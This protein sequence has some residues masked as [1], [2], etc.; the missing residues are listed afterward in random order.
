MDKPYGIHTPMYGVRRATFGIKVEEER[1]DSLTACI[2]DC[3]QDLIFLY[4]L[5]LLLYALM[6]ICARELITISTQVHSS[7]AYA[8][9]PQDQYNCSFTTQIML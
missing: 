6:W 7:F 3:K 1:Q 5:C 2:L 9:A 4:I 8:S